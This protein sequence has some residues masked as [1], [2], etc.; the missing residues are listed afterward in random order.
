MKG[1]ARTSAFEDSNPTPFAACGLF[2]ALIACP[3]LAS[4]ESDEIVVSATRSP[5]PASE[6]GASVTVVTAPE[7]ELRQYESVADVLRDRAGVSVARN[8]SF[9]GVASVRIR[10]AASG[11]SL[12]IID[13]VVVND[14]SAPSGGFNFANLDVVDIDRIEVLRGPQSILYGADAI[15]GVISVTT[16]RADAGVEVSGFLEGGALGLARGA[17]TLAGA[18]HALDARLTFSGTRTDGVSRAANGAEADGYRS[19]AASFAGGA[20]LA[21]GWR[22]EISARHGDAHAEIDG[23]PPPHFMLADTAETEDTVETALAGR[24]LFNGERLTHALVLGYSAVNRENR[25]AGVFLFG[26]E[27]ERFSAEYTAR[28]AF[29]D[30]FAA[31]VGVEGERSEA[32]VSGVDD[33]A[34]SGSVFALLET[35]LGESVS[36]SAGVRRDEFSGFDGATTA[37]ATLAWR[38]APAT[39]FR[40]SWGE[41]FRAPSLFELNF[42]LFGGP[43]N[44]DLAPERSDAFDFGVEQDIGETL[45]AK[46]TLFHQNIRNQITFDFAGGGYDNIDRTRAR[47]IE[48]EAT[49]TPIKAVSVGAN[50]ALIDAIDRATGLQLLRQPKHSGGLFVDV[51]SGGNFSFGASLFAN[52]RER[53]IGDGNEAFARLDLRA[54]YRLSETAE[55]YGRIENVTDTDYEDVSGYGEPGRSA[56]AGARVRL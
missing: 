26:A 19:I 34:R 42:N 18:N 45:N 41:G 32:R 52:G 9:G 15:G 31:L 13:G 37:R 2:L 35:R 53:D 29:T 39:T 47:G 36:M 49:W 25:D 28:F 8:S 17:A 21:T 20:Q 11:Q 24:L 40:A 38:P 6:V 3:A 51:S 16:K 1:V 44:P 4:Q 55:I 10:G 48:V 54:A 12:V 5:R 50:Y 14:P 23:F 43:A 46:V 33:H 22:A 30:D 56:F 7:I 27:G